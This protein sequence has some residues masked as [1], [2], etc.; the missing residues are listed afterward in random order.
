MERKYIFHEIIA[1]IDHSD[2]DIEFQD[3]LLGKNDDDYHDY[4][5]IESDANKHYSW[6]SEN[7]FLEINLAIQTLQDLKDKGATHVDIT[8]HCDHHAY[9][10]Y[11]NIFRLATEEEIQIAKNK[12][13]ED[14][15]LALKIELERAQQL[16][17]KEL[18]KLK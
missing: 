1:E 5:M 10:F 17:E 4:R 6:A 12:Y 14:K 8:P 7:E 18:E 15:K 3:D 11:G 13:V 2:L 16:Y 9:V